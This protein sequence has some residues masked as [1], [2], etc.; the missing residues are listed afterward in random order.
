V[1]RKL[2][3]AFAAAAIAAATFGASLEVQSDEGWC[4]IYLDGAR[5]G[6]IPLNEHR[7]TV[8][9]VAAGEHFLKIT[10]AF[11]K[12]WYEGVLT[13]EEDG[14]LRAKAEPSSFTVINRPLS[15]PAAVPPEFPPAHVRIERTD[16]ATLTTLFF[17]TSSPRGQDVYIDGAAAGV[18]PLLVA[19]L[20]AGRHK[21]RVVGAPEEEVD[22]AAGA[23][24]KLEV[25]FGP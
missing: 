16:F 18:T 4:L 10:D 17:V 19:D 8:G 5:V 3:W 2:T 6:E 25:A 15:P 11:D 22:V 13:F 12:V 1:F 14:V 21:I 9:D 20:P 23:L 7:T 24:T